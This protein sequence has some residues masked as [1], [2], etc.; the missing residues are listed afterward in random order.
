MIH[1]T[2][3][4]PLVHPTLGC[5]LC[6]LAALAGRAS[7]EDVDALYQAAGDGDAAQVS[8]LLD[9]GV[10][11]NAR[12][13][14]GSYAL[15]NAAAELRVDV[16]R[17]LLDR[18]AD[19]NVQNGQGDTPLICTIKSAGGHAATV[20]LLVEAGTD[21]A[22]KDAKGNTALDYARAKR[23]Q[24]AIALLNGRRN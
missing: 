24:Q 5:L 6:L 19:P 20:R 17:L 22:V 10:D 21:L 16:V 14:N 23:Q 9:S 2:R 15:N 12:A 1:L 7:A 11:V 3:G 18:G 4:R 8:R 13:S